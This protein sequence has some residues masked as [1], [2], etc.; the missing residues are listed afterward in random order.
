MDGTESVGYEAE[1]KA[2]VRVW[3]ALS[4]TFVFMAR[5]WERE[6][7]EET[8]GETIETVGLNVEVTVQ[9]CLLNP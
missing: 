8:D 7:G 1:E 4:L 3:W 9:A 6:T 2:L 5:M